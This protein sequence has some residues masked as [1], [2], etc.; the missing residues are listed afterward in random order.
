MFENVLSEDDVH[1][2]IGPYYDDFWLAVVES[3]KAF[4]KVKNEYE[5]LQIRTRCD[6]IRAKVLASFKRK[7]KANGD[8]KIFDFED[9]DIFII[10]IGDEILLRFKKLDESGKRA[11]FNK[12]NASNSY[13]DQEE[14]TDFLPKLNQL[15]LGWIPNA[16]WTECADINICHPKEN[17]AVKVPRPKTMRLAP[18]RSQNAQTDSYKNLPKLKIKTKLK[19]VE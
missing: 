11:N 17:W 15:I 5:N 3:F 16:T 19:K 2:K 8:V 7:F 6:L 12:T 9:Q 13:I 4:N 14:F 18:S 1:S 10:K